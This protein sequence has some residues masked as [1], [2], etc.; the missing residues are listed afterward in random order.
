MVIIICRLLATTKLSF[1]TVVHMYAT[2]TTVKPCTTSLPYPIAANLL[3]HCTSSLF[4]VVIK[5][6]RAPLL[7]PGATQ[8]L[9]WSPRDD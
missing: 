4:S 2:T 6:L 7:E 3:R 1:P 8:P 5:Y 9:T